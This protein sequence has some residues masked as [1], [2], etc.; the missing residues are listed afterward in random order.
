[1]PVVGRKSRG[2]QPPRASNIHP[3]ERDRA[4]LGTTVHNGGS[5]AAPAD[6]GACD[7]VM[8]DVTSLE[9]RTANVY[10]KKKN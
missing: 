5:R 2:G 1:M 9:L 4:L 10:S 6:G 8:C 3:R 7:T